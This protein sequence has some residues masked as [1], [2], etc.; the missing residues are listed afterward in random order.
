MP[1]EY[2][3]ISIKFAEG[4]SPM[5]K[6]RDRKKERENGIE[7]PIFADLTRV[8]Y[9]GEYITKTLLLNPI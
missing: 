6:L 2:L 4:I 3:L 7:Y 9:A 8:L 1:F 5:S